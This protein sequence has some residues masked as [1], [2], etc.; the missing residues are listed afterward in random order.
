[1]KCNTTK[2]YLEELLRQ[3]KEES[4]Y[5][6]KKCPCIFSDNTKEKQAICTHSKNYKCFYE[7]LY[8]AVSETARTGQWFKNFFPTRCNYYTGKRNTYQRNYLIPISFTT[9]FFTCSHLRLLGVKERAVSP[10][11]SEHPVR[12]LSPSPALHS[13]ADRQTDVLAPQR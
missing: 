5:C 7:K 9:S 2:I 8:N 11:P 3:A 6:L 4:S 10:L 1:M 13:K 12:V